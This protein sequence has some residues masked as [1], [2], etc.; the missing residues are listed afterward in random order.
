MCEQ[1]NQDHLN[2]SGQVSAQ[3]A[4]CT[5]LKES[6]KEQKDTKKRLVIVPASGL[7]TLLRKFNAI[8]PL[9]T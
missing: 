4:P 9:Q 5:C 6:E 8:V 3:K 2:S 1:A 7:T